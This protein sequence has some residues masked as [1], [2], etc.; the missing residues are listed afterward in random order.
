MCYSIRYLWQIEALS[1][2]WVE[3]NPSNICFFPMDIHCYLASW[4]YANGLQM[5]VY[6]CWQMLDWL[7]SSNPYLPAWVPNKNRSVALRKRTCKC[8]ISS[9]PQTVSFNLSNKN[10]VKS[11]FQKWF[12]SCCNKLACFGIVRRWPNIFLQKESLT[13]SGTVFTTLHFLHNL[14]IGPIS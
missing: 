4:Y 14:R 11:S 13:T 9:K 7:V 12:L 10:A 6:R 8:D 5:S 2:Q 1:S 3:T